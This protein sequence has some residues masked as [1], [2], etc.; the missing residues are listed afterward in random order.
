MHVRDQSRLEAR[1]V[2]GI[3]TGDEAAFE[4]LFRAYYDE[5]CGFAWRYVRS[6]EIA[7]DLVQDVLGG[8]WRRRVRWRPTTTVRA[9]LYGAVRNEALKHLAREDVALRW[10]QQA[11]QEAPPRERT[12]DE[13]LGYEELAETV[14]GVIDRLPERRRLIFVLHRQHGLTYREIADLLEIA[15][16][17]VETQIGRALDALRKLL[18]AL[19][20]AL[21]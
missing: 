2:E 19:L 10:R 11:R 18:A 6:A 7:E 15:P 12:P 16:S 5:L 13:E 3:R 1:W 21:F 9:Y 20:P 17:T 8:I 4:A 14:Q